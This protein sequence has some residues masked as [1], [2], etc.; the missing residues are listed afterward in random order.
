L[1]AELRQRRRSTFRAIELG[2]ANGALEA[3]DAAAAAQR[4]R[5]LVIEITRAISKGTP[6]LGHNKEVAIQGRLL[7]DG[8]EVA[9]FSGMRG[10]RGGWWGVFKSACEVLYRCQDTLGTDIVLWLRNPTKNAMIGEYAK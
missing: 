10:S 2:S 5:V 9:S 8:N 7:E 1:R 3:T 6:Y 4:G